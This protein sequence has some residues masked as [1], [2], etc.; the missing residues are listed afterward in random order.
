M[1]T[2]IRIHSTGGPEVLQLDAIDLDEP[3]P[4]ELQVEV[5]AAGVNFIDIYHRSGQYPVPLPYVLGG[6]G[7]G[8]VTA[9]G[10][11]VEALAVGDRVAWTMARGSYATDA[12]IEERCAVHVPDDIELAVAAAVMTQGITAEFLTRSI[13]HVR[14]G[15]DVL[16]HAGAGGVGHL[17]IPMLRRAGARVI[18]TVSS[19]DKAEL[20]E[21]VGGEVLVGYDDFAERVRELTDGRGVHAA[22][23]GVGATT[24]D[25]TLDSIAVRG[26]LVLFGAASGPV[27]P[28]DPQVLNRKGS[29]KLTRPSIVHF[30][31]ERD[32]YDERAANVFDMV[33]DGTLDVRIHAEFPLAEAAE[34]HRALESRRTTGKLL[35]VP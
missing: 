8:R 25:G 28:L 31:S 2:A 13:V 18:T 4:G 24:F 35:L 33:R 5:A 15:D 23:D 16:V 7:S 1:T 26:T 34:A 3:G 17:L 19:P 12:V 29:L 22:Y 32:E 11:G 10:S 14:E 6:E 30:I 20:A 27:A 9:V 21:S